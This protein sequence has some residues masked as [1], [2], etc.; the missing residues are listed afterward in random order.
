MPGDHGQQVSESF[1]PP[2]C[3]SRP[4]H[5]VQL[6]RRDE[7]ER[8]HEW[9]ADVVTVL[10]VWE[11][12]AE[13]RTTG[14]PLWVKE[15]RGE[16]Y[17]SRTSLHETRRGL[18]LKV[19]CEG[20]GAFEYTP[21][22][23]GI[24]WL[25]GGTGPAHYFQTLGLS[26]W[27]ER[28]GT[29]CIHANAVAAGEVA[30]GLI[31]PSRTGKTTLTAALLECGLQLMTDDMLALHCNEGRRWVY[32]GW[33]QLRMW[34]DSAERF[35]GRELAALA[36]VHERFDKRVVEVAPGDG[37]RFCAYRRPLAQLFLLERRQASSTGKPGE[38]EVAIEQVSPG[39]AMIH[40]LQNGM[41]ADA[42][43][44][45]GVEGSRLGTLAELLHAVPLKRI[46][47]P[48]GAA[49]LPHVCELIQRELAE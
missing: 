12:A 17:H 33:P 5:G 45:L 26:L 11:E 8:A 13:P 44:A 27:L 35:A 4:L 49:Y 9:G 20:K 24:W 31:A 21:D 38:D 36:R 39:A 43:Q 34:P 23:I 32:P 6:V 3:F 22:G 1:L 7:R 16:R 30:I 10:E 29:P 28:R 37:S 14:A 18:L 15:D 2:R 40:L 47:Y 48:S 42:C 25:A 46:T 41:L 19:D